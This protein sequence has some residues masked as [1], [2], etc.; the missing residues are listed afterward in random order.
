MNVLLAFGGSDPNRISSL[1]LPIIREN[2]QVNFSLIL[3]PGFENLDEFLV[4]CKAEENLKCFVNISNMAE[5]LYKADLCIVSGG[6]TMYE[7]AYLQK[8]MII[9]CQVEHQVIN[10]E[11]IQDISSQINL[12]IINQ[13]KKEKIDLINEVLKGKKEIPEPKTIHNFV[14]GKYRIVEIVDELLEERK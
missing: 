11:G 5:M 10:A 1:M 4:E 13:E 6:L 7:C 9:A 8:K 2:K 12:G 14:N 3:G